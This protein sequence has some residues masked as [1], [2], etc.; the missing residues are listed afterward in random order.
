[1]R[2]ESPY[3]LLTTLA[4]YFCLTGIESLRLSRFFWGGVIAGYA[5]LVRP[6]AIGFLAVIPAGIALRWAFAHRESLVWITA[7]VGS[8]C[9]G[10]FIFALPFIVY[11]SIDTGNIGALSRKAG[12][13]LEINLRESGVLNE[14][15]PAAGQP[16]EPLSFTDYIRRHPARYLKKVIGDLAPA[17]GVFFEALHYSYVPFLLVGLALVLREKFWAGTNLLLLLFVSFYVF[18]FALIYVKRRYSLQAVPISLG[19]V[20]LGMWW[21]R[22]KLRS[23]LSSK[24][25]LASVTCA[26]LMILATTLPKTLKPISREKAYVREAGWYL[27]GRNRQGDLRVA[28]LDDRITFYAESK[29]INVGGV[30]QAKLAALLREQHAEYLAAEAKAFH[31]QFPDVS[32]QPESH[33]LVLEKKFIG[34]RKDEMLVFRVI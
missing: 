25:A 11:L 27:K 18:A 34:S 24:R 31:A 33:G 17:I 7:S 22:D 23:G 6:E 29:N 12:V 13:T 1:V 2:T 8:L 14:Q 20:A 26:A 16:A 32:R 30:D 4:L 5:Y 9:C 15:D 28:V 21:V 3:L 10:F 19:W